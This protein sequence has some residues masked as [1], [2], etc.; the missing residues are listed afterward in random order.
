MSGL[1]NVPHLRLGQVAGVPVTVDAT[2][3]LVVAYIALH[4]AQR[5]LDAA[6]YAS[7]GAILLVG[8]FGSLLLHEAGHAVMASR[9]GYRTAGIWIGAGFG[10]ALVEMPEGRNRD[11]VAILAAGPATNLLLAA[12]IFAVLNAPGLFEASA[13]P[14]PV[15]FTAAWPRG[16]AFFAIRSVGN[17]N[18]ALAAVNLLPAFPLDGGRIYRIALRGW[19]AD[20]NGV[21]IIAGLGLASGLW[22]LLAAIAYSGG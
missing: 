7:V 3:L 10:L 13:Y 14:P 18:L 16:P 20:R 5:T 21:R 17:L 8:A 6:G 4:V 2:Y 11:A 15:E 9:L 1:D 22:C 12:A 19:L